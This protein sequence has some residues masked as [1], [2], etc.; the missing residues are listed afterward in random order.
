MKQLVSPIP[1]ILNLKI[2]KIKTYC[3]LNLTIPQALDKTFGYKSNGLKR[4]AGRTGAVA[5]Q[6]KGT[7][8][9]PD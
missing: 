8:P 3:S 5:P 2:S 9:D 4:E 6:K 7:L 1:N